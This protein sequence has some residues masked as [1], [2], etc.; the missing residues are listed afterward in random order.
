MS[1]CTSAPPISWPPYEVIV[2]SAAN[3]Y[4]TYLSGLRAQADATLDQ[5]A[6][7]IMVSLQAAWRMRHALRPAD[8]SFTAVALGP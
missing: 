6:R 5:V 2:E 8:I 7:K 1:A 4:I 3:Q